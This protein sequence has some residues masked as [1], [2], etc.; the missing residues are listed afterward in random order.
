MFLM[1]TLGSIELCCGSHR[2]RL[3]A[4]E[5]FSHYSAII[6]LIHKQ[7]VDELLAAGELGGRQAA[8]LLKASVVEYLRSKHPEVPANA[9]VTV[10]VYANLGGLG[11]AYC[12][13]KVIGHPAELGIF[14]NG[15]N[16]EDAL[17]DLVNA[18]DG[19]ECADEKL[20][21]KTYYGRKQICGRKAN[22]HSCV[23]NEL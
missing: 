15:F 5:S 4:S 8:R 23:P 21:G 10:R 17:C 22:D 20:K 1:L 2:W 13:A 18:G 19:K 11:R 9:K 16:K 6:L 7:F 14:V 3:H 12:D